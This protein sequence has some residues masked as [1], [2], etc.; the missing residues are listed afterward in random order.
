MPAVLEWIAAAR[1]QTGP[2]APAPLE[3][4]SAVMQREGEV[5]RF[6]YDGRVIHVRDS[7]GVRD[8][9]VLLASPGVEMPAGEIEARAEAAADGAP[10]A[11]ASAAAEAGL[12]VHASADA[13]LTGL[14]ATAKSQYRSRL[15]ELREEI[16]QAEGWNDPER[17]AR[18]REEM[19]LIASQ[20]SAAVG[21][22]GRDRPLASGAER[23]RLRVTRAIHT[24][25]RRL[26]EQ[27]E[28]LGYE[29]GATVRTG[30]FC[31]YEPDPRRP[32]SWRIDGG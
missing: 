23:A 32:I 2:A 30:S 24:A 13:A 21:L 6:D 14:D 9:A 18:A 4:L 27:D 19:D 22:G 7:K 31:A 17:A 10:R 29:L 16:E 15:E 3:P 20:L 5:W 25:I 12:A 1:P 28:A 8:L 11:D 26:G